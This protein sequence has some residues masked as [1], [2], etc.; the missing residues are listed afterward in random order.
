MRLTRLLPALAAT[1]LS[2]GLDPASVQTV[3]I[4]GFAAILR[5]LSL[6]GHTSERGALRGDASC[7]CAADRVGYY[8]TLTGSA[9]H[10]GCRFAHYEF[11]VNLD[12]VGEFFVGQLLQQGASSKSTHAL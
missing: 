3:L 6:N 12:G 5:K 4:D 1:I 9:A 7:A 11:R 10:L 8:A 2:V